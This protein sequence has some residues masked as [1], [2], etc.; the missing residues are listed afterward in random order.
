MQVEE[1]TKES[2]LIAGFYSGFLG[3]DVIYILS[4]FL[5]I[6][7][8]YYA[9]LVNTKI[10]QELSIKLIGFLIISYIIGIILNDIGHK[11]ILSLEHVDLKKHIEDFICLSE[12]NYKCAFIIQQ[13]LL[14]NYDKKI[15]G[16]FERLEFNLILGSSF[17]AT[18]L[19]GGIIIMVTTI[20]SLLPISYRLG[21]GIFLIILGIL[22][23]KRD[24]LI[25]KLD[26]DKNKKMREDIKS[27]FMKSFFATLFLFGGIIIVIV[28]IFNIF[29]PSYIYYR[30]GFAIFLI[31]LGILMRNF[32]RK[33]FIAF[34]QEQ[35]HLLT[36]IR[37]RKQKEISMMLQ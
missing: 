9:Q 21:F 1:F 27:Y 3:R 4:G 14:D 13:D 35:I 7:F 15:T 8:L 32:G 37:R 6:L 12:L 34:R 16:I 17:A 22:I 33:S 11:K 23:Q 29:L 19:F 10:P 30:L 24:K 25:Q 2:S 26:N 20:Y 31:I 36:E 5:F 28:T 18:F